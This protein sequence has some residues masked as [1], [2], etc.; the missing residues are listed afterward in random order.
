MI[1]HTQDRTSPSRRDTEGCDW[2]AA[3]KSGCRATFDHIAPRLFATFQRRGRMKGLSAE[4]A[5]EVANQTLYAVWSSA[6][7]YSGDAA[8]MSWALAIHAHKLTDQLRRNLDRR[9]REV[10][11][12]EPAF[13]ESLHA[14]AFLGE[15]SGEQASDPSGLASQDW[16]TPESWLNVKRLCDAVEHAVARLPPAQQDVARLA[17]GAQLTTREIAD[18]LGKPDGTIKA[19]QFQAIRKIRQE[20]RT[21]GFDPHQSPYSHGNQM[22]QDFHPDRASGTCATIS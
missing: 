5:D 6:N 7:S 3:I 14:A 20:L 9:R 12:D 16:K 4:D 22:F 1:A 17:L 21:L 13:A 2:L 15:A 18:K 19:T 8:P 11:S 10:S